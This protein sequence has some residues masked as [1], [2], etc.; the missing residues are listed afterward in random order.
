METMTETTYILVHGAW[1]GEW[2]WRDVG[3]ELTRRDVQWTAVDLPSSTHGAHPNTFL[4][5]D[6]HEVIE[7]A[8]LDGPVVLVGHSY[9]GAVIT[10]AADR[11][12]NLERLIYIA[13]LVPRLDQSASEIIEETSVRTLL[14]QAIEV[15]GDYLRLNPER[16]AAALYQD[17]TEEVAAWAVSNLTTQTI[18]S[19]RSPRSSFDVEVPSY[20]VRCSLDYGI[21]PSVQ[22]VMSGRCGEVATL[23]SGHSPMLSQPVALCDLLLTSA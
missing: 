2:C 23:E 20:Y 13:A 18:A 17:C 10:E 21:D 14:D 5:D 3:H 15:E 7:I 1:G 9:G 11:V 22:E 19:L 4:G 12:P 16:A 8:K 6:A